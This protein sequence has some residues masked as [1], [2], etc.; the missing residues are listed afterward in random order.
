M[1]VDLYAGTGGFI[2]EAILGKSI[3]MLG[4]LIY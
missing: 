3:I 4:L 2:L 1:N